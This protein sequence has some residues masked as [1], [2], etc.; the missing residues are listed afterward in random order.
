MMLFT[1]DM[2]YPEAVKALF[3]AIEGKSDK[4]REE[5]YAEYKKIV[6]EITKNELKEPAYLTGYIF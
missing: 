6:P 5:I 4:E 2:T 1:K 3:R